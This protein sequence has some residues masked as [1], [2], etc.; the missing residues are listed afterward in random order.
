MFE[1]HLEALNHPEPKQMWSCD[2]NSGRFCTSRKGRQGEVCGF[3]HRM[4]TA[5]LCLG[6]IADRS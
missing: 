1:N 3:T 2:V 4:K 6:I 5:W